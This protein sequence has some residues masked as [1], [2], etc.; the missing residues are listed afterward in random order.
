MTTMT[1]HLE[2]N[3]KCRTDRRNDIMLR[4]TSSRKM[5][6]ISTKIFVNK[7][8]FNAKAKHGSWV[9]QSD[10]AYAKKNQQLKEIMHK[11]ESVPSELEKNGITPTLESVANYLKGKENGSTKDFL[12]FAKKIIDDLKSTEQVNTYKKYNTSL[13][14]LKEYLGTRSLMFSDLNVAFIRGYETYLKTKGNGINTIQKEIKVL[15]AILYRAIKEDLLPQEKN[16]FFRISIKSGKTNKT[17]LTAIEIKKIESLNLIEGSTLWHT[18]NYFLFSYYGAG[19]RFSDFCRLTWSNVKNG[20][21]NYQM[22][23]TGEYKS[24]KLFPQA[25]KILKHYEK[26]KTKDTDF[27][28]PLLSKKY[29]YK[30]MFFLFNKISSRNTIVNKNLKKIAKLIELDKNLSFH[31]SRHSFADVARTKKMSVYD[32][33]KA[34]G[35]SSIKMTENYLNSLDQNSVDE[36][37]G[38]VFEE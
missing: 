17:K 5:K 35:H 13:N 15:R 12:L 34:L 28:F 20:R 1:V 22:N 7:A 16:P 33:S 38:K 29:T 14:K 9:R 36:G 10:P 2:L 31:I 27:I 18:C 32:I 23:K 4:L 11:A 19:I 8:D 37:M 3:S 21:L 6:R 24:I 26:D 30:D 25:L